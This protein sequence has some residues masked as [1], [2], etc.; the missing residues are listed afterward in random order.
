MG[1]PLVRQDDLERE[2]KKLNDKINRVKREV[3]AEVLEYLESLGLTGP[4]TEA[5]PD[6]PAG[7]ELAEAGEPD[8]AAPA[9][10]GDPEGIALVEAIHE[11]KAEAKDATAL[12]PEES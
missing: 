1:S 2:K 11:R 5:D 9:G 6:A 7:D 4:A 10:V 12:F 3:R 8:E